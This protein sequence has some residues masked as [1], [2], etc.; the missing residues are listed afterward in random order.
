MCVKRKPEKYY[1]INTCVADIL[2]DNNKMEK[3]SNGRKKNCKLRQVGI[4][5]KLVY[6]I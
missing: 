3:K 4:Y 1:I 5:Y 6:D 2:Y